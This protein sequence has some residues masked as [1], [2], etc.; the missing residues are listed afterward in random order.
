MPGAAGRGQAAL[1]HDAI[2]RRVRACPACGEG[3]RKG[4]KEGIT[5]NYCVLL[6]NNAKVLQCCHVAQCCGK[7][8]SG[9]GGGGG[10]A[11]CTAG[12]HVTNLSL[13]VAV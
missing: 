3:R 5:Y 1:E 9:R 13:S 8:W 10:C 6:L 11:L 2:A 7:L 12:G 4:E